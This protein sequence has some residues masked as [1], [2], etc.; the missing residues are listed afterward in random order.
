[1]ALIKCTECSKEMEDTVSACPNCGAPRGTTKTEVKTGKGIKPLW[2]IIGGIIVVV[3][4]GIVIVSMRAQGGSSSSLPNISTGSGLE[5]GRYVVSLQ[6][7]CLA[8]MDWN[9]NTFDNPLDV[10]AVIY[11]NG[12]SVFE[13]TIK[14]DPRGERDP[15][16]K[17]AFELDYSKN[18]NYQIKLMEDAIVATAYERVYPGTPVNGVWLFD[19]RIPFG[20]NSW[21]LFKSEKVK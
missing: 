4:I 16:T 7:I 19:G 17:V 14:G 12:N 3:I 6:K 8:E 5:E 20:N 1:M 2:L 15:L 18:A 13:W 11:K 9:K 21:L 10:K